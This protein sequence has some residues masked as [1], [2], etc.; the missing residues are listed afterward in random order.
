MRHRHEFKGKHRN[1]NLNTGVA[2]HVVCVRFAS[3]LL[4]KFLYSR[5]AA[6]R[7]AK[8]WLVLTLSFLHT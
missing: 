7:R 2:K 6:Q 8:Q 5:K 4:A 1:T 3:L